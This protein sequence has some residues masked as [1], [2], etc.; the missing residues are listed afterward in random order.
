MPA[1]ETLVITDYDRTLFDTGRFEQ[2][3]LQT[4]SRHYQL[5]EPTFRAE[6]TERSIGASGYDLLA[7]LANYQIDAADF[8][9]VLD[10]ELAG[11][12]CLYSDTLPFLKYLTGRPDLAMRLVTVGAPSY[13][14]LKLRALRRAH[15]HLPMHII[16][17]NKGAWLAEQW[18]EAK[19]QPQP[20]SRLSFQGQSYR[21]AIVIDDRADSFRD[22]Q[23]HPLVTGIHI[24]RPGSKYQDRQ[25]SLATVESLAQAVD[26]IEQLCV[27]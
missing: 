11:Q 21:Q 5:D 26:V 7:H 9:S 3:V 8:T 16:G 2:I 22:I 6:I 19:L 10:H 24:V 25:P 18:A 20:T 17:I 15:P 1:P 12:D 23:Q 27:S 14:Q 4:L 13:Q